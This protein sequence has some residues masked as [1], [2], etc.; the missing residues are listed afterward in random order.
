MAGSRGRSVASMGGF[1]T[2]VFVSGQAP[3]GQPFR[4]RGWGIPTSDSWWDRPG[5]WNIKLLPEPSIV[6]RSEG[7]GI[8]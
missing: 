5:K 8:L 4:V 2:P 1:L 7:L 6:A 3:A